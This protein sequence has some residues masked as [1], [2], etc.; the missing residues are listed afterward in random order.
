[1]ET[2]LP[3]FVE[4]KR[5]IVQ[6]IKEKR[7]RFGHF[8]PESFGKTALF[9]RKSIVFRPFSAAEKVDAQ[10]ALGHVVD[11]HGDPVAGKSP[12]E[13]ENEQQ[14]QRNTKRP[15]AENADEKGRF[16]IRRAA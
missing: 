16:G 9:C 11:D 4:E 7:K 5:E 1:M 15:H 2:S 12:E 10:G 3:S 6:Q 13:H 8:A 14:G